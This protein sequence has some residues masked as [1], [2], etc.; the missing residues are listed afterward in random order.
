MAVLPAL[1]PG[2]LANPMLA[3]A[4]DPATLAA[5]LQLFARTVGF[6][7]QLHNA[8]TGLDLMMALRG[9]DREQAVHALRAGRAGAAGEHRD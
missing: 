7:Y 6:P 3:D 1:D 4:P 5:R 9:K 2:P 8:T